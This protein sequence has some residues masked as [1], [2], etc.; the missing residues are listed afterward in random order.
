M[1]ERVV[2]VDSAERM[3]IRDKAVEYDVPTERAVMD[4]EHLEFPPNTFDCVL[5]SLSL[6]WINNLPHVFKQIHDCLKP[7]CPFIGAMV[8]GDTLYEL[9]TALQ[10]AESEREG[11]ISPHVSP[12]TDVRDVGS[13]L[14]GAG[15]GLVTVD[16]DEIQVCYPSMYELMRDLRDMGESNAVAARKPYL[17][18]ATMQ[19]AAEIYKDVY[20]DPDGI[21]ATFNIIYLIGWKPDPDNPIRVKERGSA[22][23]SFKDLDSIL[24][25]AGAEADHDSPACVF[26]TPKK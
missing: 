17:R 20:G 4:E 5:S 12:M 23:A 16:M 22:A 14:G 24:D 6:H 13:L 2:Q 18:R 10:L 26:A 21:T 15:F 3:L 11:G 19:R 9:R 25:T 7:D 8:G 1:T